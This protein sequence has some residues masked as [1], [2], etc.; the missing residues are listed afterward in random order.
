LD[1]CSNKYSVYNALTWRNLAVRTPLNAMLNTHAG[2]YGSLPL[3]NLSSA[4]GEASTALT[5]SYHQTPRNVDYDIRQGVM[6]TPYH[7]SSIYFGP[8]GA[9][10][11]AK[12]QFYRDNAAVVDNLTQQSLSIWLMMPSSDVAGENVLFSWSDGGYG[13]WLALS[14]DGDIVFQVH[15]ATGNHQWRSPDGAKLGWFSDNTGLYDAQWH[16]IVFSFDQG[17]D[18]RWREPTTSIDYNTLGERALGWPNIWFDGV[19]QPLTY[20]PAA[21]VDR[22]AGL[23]PAITDLGDVCIGTKGKGNTASSFDGYLQHISLWNSVLTRDQVQDLFHMPGYEAQGP[24]DLR[25][26]NFV[27]TDPQA[28]KLVAWWKFDRPEFDLSSTVDSSYSGDII[29]DHAPIGNNL[30]LTYNQGFSGLDA[31]ATCTVSILDEDDWDLGDVLVL[32]DMKGV[33]HIFTAVDSGNDIAAKQIQICT[34]ACSDIATLRGY[35]IIVING[36]AGFNAT[37]GGAANQITVSQV[38]HGG[39]GNQSNNYVTGD[40]ISVTAFTGGYPTT[41]TTEYAGPKW[42]DTKCVAKYDNWF[43]QHPIPANDFGYA[44]ITASADKSVGC[45]LVTT[46]SF[47]TASLHGSYMKADQYR[48]FGLSQG[49]TPLDGSTRFG[50]IPTDF[51][52]LNN[53]IYE[54]VN[55]DTNTLGYSSNFSIWSYVNAGPPGEATETDLTT[56][57]IG[58]GFIH[59]NYMAGLAGSGGNGNGPGGLVNSINSHR[60]GVYGYPSWKQIRTGEHPVA[61]EHKKNN[62]L[63]VSDEPT[64]RTLT[65]GGTTQEITEMKAST[66]TN[67]VEPPVSFKHTSLVYRVGSM[68]RGIPQNLTVQTSYANNLT[69]FANVELANRFSRQSP[70]RQ[71]YDDFKDM[72][73]VSEESVAANPLKAFKS[74]VYRETIYPKGVNTFLSGTRSRLNYAETAAVISSS[75]NGKYRTFW[76]DDLTDRKRDDG[77]ANS[78]GYPVFANPNQLATNV[79]LGHLEFAWILGSGSLSI[80]P[81]DVGKGKRS[82]ESFNPA[83]S[84]VPGTGS[85]DLTVDHTSG[86][87]EYGGTWGELQKSTVGSLFASMSSTKLNRLNGLA[88]EYT[89]TIAASTD[90]ADLDGDI[91]RLI[92]N[93]GTTKN[94]IFD[95]DDDGA[96]GTLDGDGYTRV[97]LDADGGGGGE[98]HNYPF[99]ILA[100]LKEAIEHSNGHDGDIIVDEPQGIGG[101]LVATLRL[102]QKFAGAGG[103]SIVT[104][105]TGGGE[106]T[107]AGKF[108]G[109]GTFEGGL[110]GGADDS[111]QPTNFQQ[112]SYAG[113]FMNDDN[114]KCPGTAS[115]CF[116]HFSLIPNNTAT[117]GQ[118]YNHAEAYPVGLPIRAGRG[119][120]CA[121]L[122]PTNWTTNFWSGRNPWHD[123]YEVYSDD[124]RKMGQGYSVLPE[125]RISDHMDY[126][127]ENG[128]QDVKNFA[129][130]SLDGGSVSSSADTPNGTYTEQFWKEYCHSD[131]L[132]QFDVIQKDH[133]GVAALSAI[134]LKC[135]VIKKLLPYNGFYPVQRSL[136]LGSLLSSS[137]APY[138]SGSSEADYGQEPGGTINSAGSNYDKY[139][140]E[141]LQSFLQPFYAPGI[142]YNSIKSG[143][144]VDYPIHT[145]S[146]KLHMVGMQGAANAHSGTPTHALGSCMSISSLPDMR[147][148]FEALINPDPFLPVSSSVANNRETVD[149]ETAGR[150]YLTAPYYGSSSF[151][152]TW[153]GSSKPNYSM[154]ANNFAAEVPNFFLKNKT[155]TTFRSAEES[156]YVP[157]AS[158]STYFMDV[159]LYQSPDMLMSWHYPGVNEG[160]R[161]LKAGSATGWGFGPRYSVQKIYDGANPTANTVYET[162]QT[163]NTTNTG[164]PGYAPHVPPYLY[165]RA[166]ARLAFSPHKVVDM[167][168]DT[169]IQFGVSDI[170]TNI[171]LDDE[172]SF[173][174]ELGAGQFP[175]LSS[176]VVAL[177][178]GEGAASHARMSVSSSINIYGRTETPSMEFDAVTRLPKRAMQTGKQSWVIH[179]KWECPTL[180]FANGKG[181]GLGPGELSSSM[182]LTGSWWTQ[183]FPPSEI[184]RP[185]EMW[186]GHGSIPT[187]ETGIFFGIRESFPHTTFRGRASEKFENSGSLLQACG[188]RPEQRR[189]GELAT[190][191]WISEA[192][193]AI[194]FTDVEGRRKFFALGNTLRQSRTLFN[195]ALQGQ[196]GPGRSI[197]QMASRMPR[198]VIPPHLDFIH[199]KSL[200]PF[201]MYIF[202]FSERLNQQDLSNIWQNVM[203]DIAVTAKKATTALMHNTG[204]NEFFRGN[205]MP[206]HT[207]WMVFKVK[208]RAASDYFKLTAD[209]ADDHMYSFNFA[210]GNH[211]AIPDYTYNWPYDFFSL[212]ELAKVD[213]KLGIGND[214]FPVT[215]SRRFPDSIL[216]PG[217]FRNLTAQQ[218]AGSNPQSIFG[219]AQAAM[220]LGASMDTLDLQEAASIGAL[221]AKVGS[222]TDKQQQ[223][224]AIAVAGAM[225]NMQTAGM[226]GMPQ[227]TEATMISKIMGNQSGAGQPGEMTYGPEEDVAMGGIFNEVAQGAAQEQTDQGSAANQAPGGLGTAGA[228][229]METNNMDGGSGKMMA[230]MAKMMGGD[231]GD[232]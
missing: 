224:A 226:S 73:L 202:E 164:C 35:F 15:G 210:Q 131:F 75:H 157:M 78:M 189:V 126:Y 132:H 138:L 186:N 222:N 90:A 150:L 103:N 153:N 118:T 169:T 232:F 125:F 74:L 48:R 151:Y 158:G 67:Y 149:P 50:W 17:G 114:F 26:L 59:K 30:N 145:S 83:L 137:Y 42:Y 230:M 161:N 208:R 1:R 188:F 146:A 167:A 69:T 217:G 82:T 143:I 80:W 77:A 14:T 44:W 200:E 58:E 84:G 19:Q 54:P 31:M 197:V 216:G 45:D 127:I 209:T 171:K 172:T 55:S 91:I 185:M 175:Y 105:T 11:P 76:R 102:Q 12:T 51:V 156:K 113:H 215:P 142:M 134:S 20:V 3:S 147:M 36:Q 47:V 100:E 112:S 190:G 116:S 99:T 106:I 194:P 46:A 9:N 21:G 183:E 24:G 5:A 220:N 196:A 136:Q 227:G 130:L 57:N 174:T 140:A 177:G 231:N 219:P 10:G 119:D 154:A 159:V 93:N 23:N 141:R 27:S 89:I 39:S 201:A 181:G 7:T 162:D 205:K 70:A 66:H 108:G 214:A 4:D 109:A 60:G 104:I 22:W 123:S 191:K 182:A 170:L 61:R 121:G 206:A 117:G 101:N 92:D 16:H 128:F 198:Y 148:P 135:S 110:S 144:A 133:D 115:Q 192:I 18:Q 2:K 166:V 184:D 43:I 38:K 187:G 218:I 52:G 124:I 97:Q 179:S 211:K 53:N 155:L 49:D 223:N 87:N 229:G 225:K 107:G 28:N 165:G 180:N 25:R 72:Y 96:T 94:Y 120:G 65:H 173:F 41:S 176:S 98:L 8:Q 204:E 13:A 68:A 163:Q 29:T 6:A 221:L 160:G 199:N 79:G 178:M 129:F 111:P 228:A 33:K 56:F 85:T 81:L 71:M 207:R 62:I 95:D 152:A 37:T 63:S 122:T 32:T 213:I 168:E 86:E 88:A 64:T 203:P 195:K 212:V 34:G 193:V 139:F 40:G